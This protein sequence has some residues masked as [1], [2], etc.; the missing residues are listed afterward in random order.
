MSEITAAA[1]AAPA[2]RLQAAARALATANAG[3]SRLVALLVDPE[4]DVERVLAELDRDPALAARVLKVANSPFYGRAGQVGTVRH[5][6]AMLGLTAVRSIAAAGCLDRLMPAR[7]GPAFGADRFRRHSLA[8][9]LTARE[10]ARQL[11]PGL[12]AEAYMAGLLHDVGVLVLLRAAPEATARFDA[13]AAAGDGLQAE[14]DALGATHEDAGRLL[15]Q[16]WQMPPWLVDSLAGH[17]AARAHSATP[18]GEPLAAL[19]ALLGL[20]DSL[21][22]RAGLGLWPADEAA[23]EV[24]AALDAAALQTWVDALPGLVD[25]LEG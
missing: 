12:E 10:L 21:A 23:A 11:L 24:P 13:Q 18:G 15:A 6:V 22:C 8:V 25:Q 9:A 14:R 3:A 16:A 1:P 20:A 2:E 17:H 5:A 4:V 19:P 7:S